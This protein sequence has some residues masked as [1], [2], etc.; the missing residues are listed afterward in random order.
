VDIFSK[1][2]RSTTIKK[3]GTTII[4]YTD[5]TELILDKNGKTISLK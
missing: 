4:L 2:R 5:G 3:D 1:E